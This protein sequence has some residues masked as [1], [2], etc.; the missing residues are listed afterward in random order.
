MISVPNIFFC[1]FSASN[2]SEVGFSGMYAN[3]SVGLLAPALLLKI[4]A[5][6]SNDKRKEFMYKE[7]S[8]I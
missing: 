2:C 4:K 7:S 1:D 5:N 6:P 8:S 3:I